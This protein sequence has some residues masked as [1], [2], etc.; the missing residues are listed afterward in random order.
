V[1]CQ[2][3]ARGAACNAVTLASI[4]PPSRH[5]H[6][7]LSS[8]LPP[9]ISSADADGNRQTGDA[10]PAASRPCLVHLDPSPARAAP[11]HQTLGAG[12][13]SPCPRAAAAA[14][15]AAHSRRPHTGQP[16]AGVAWGPD[17]PDPRQVP[18][19]RRPTYLAHAAAAAADPS[20]GQGCTPV[21][22]VHAAACRCHSPEGPRCQCRLS[23]VEHSCCHV[24]P[25]LP[26]SRDL[27]CLQ[28][29]QLHPCGPSNPLDG[30]LHTSQVQSEQQM[31]P[32][33]HHHKA[34]LQSH[35][36]TYCCV[37]P[38]HIEPAAHDTFRSRSCSQSHKDAMP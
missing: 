31:T 32:S 8:A 35:P 29:L 13:P 25:D 34:P 24:A 18:V 27:A 5:P 11:H 2:R 26:H 16:H 38:A 28:L 19:A 21:V 17:S 37:C 4:P 20:S 10:A 30:P 7:A 33:G 36:P 9:V 1:S 14:A 22:G 6:A 23:L 12:H 15:A 3:G